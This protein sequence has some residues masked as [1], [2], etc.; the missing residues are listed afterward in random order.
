MR[1]LLLFAAT[2]AAASSAAVVALVVAGE[3]G[4]SEGLFQAESPSRIILHHL[5]YQVK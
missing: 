3:E 5:L 1:S 4:M 2:T